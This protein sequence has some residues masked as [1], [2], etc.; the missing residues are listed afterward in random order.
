[1][2]KPLVIIGGGITGL[3]AAYLAARAGEKVVV[4][5]G[6]PQA[7]GLLATFTVNNTRLE[8]YYH[9]FFTHDAE[10]RW[11]V[12][13]LGL[14]EHLQFNP[15]TMGIFRAGRLYDFNGPKDLL[16]FAPLSPAAKLRFGATSFYLG[17]LADWRRHEN[18][19]A[20]EW[21]Y[22]YAGPAATEA[23]WRPM[24]EVKFGP[25]AGQV[26]VAWMIGRLKQRLGS[27]ERGDER[28][29]YLRGSLNVLLDAL[30]KELSALGVKIV[31][32]ARVDKLLIRQNAL[33]AVQTTA[34]EFEGSRFL[35]TIPTVH[36]VPLLQEARPDFARRLAE[37]K[38]FGAVCTIL[39]LDRPLSQVYWLNVADSGFPFGGVIEHTNFIPSNVYGGRHLVYLSRYFEAGNALA[40][41]PEQE[42]ARIMIDPLDRIYPQFDRSHVHKAHVFRTLTAATV[43]DL[44]FSKKVPPVVTPLANLYLATMAHVYPDERSCNNSIR[45]AANACRLLGIDTSVVPTGASLAGQ[46]GMG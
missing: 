12:H 24:L 37:I 5:E 40:S 15:A 25:F 36:L 41:M 42:L 29:G 10:I 14:D 13:E 34:G 17:K 30:M 31:L 46:V 32:Q 4:L 7:G 19:P 28:L 27:R 33:A 39:E 3:T 35:A 44:Q 38:Y 26:P 22:R 2:S 20:L 16:R 6:S 18:V 8:Q 43:C 45:V 23:V 11:L 1:M 21:F 9:H